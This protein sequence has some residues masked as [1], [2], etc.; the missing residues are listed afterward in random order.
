[1]LHV[2]LANYG[3][4]ALC[5]AIALTQ[6]F[7][8]KNNG[9]EI[10][11][12]ANSGQQARILFDMIKNF[13]ESLDPD[14]LIL[15]RYRDTIKMPI[16]KSSVLVLNSDAM[17]QDGGGYSLFIEDEFAAAKNWDIWNVLVSGQG[18]QEQPL[19][20]AI[21]SANFLLD[22]FPAF[23]WRKTCMEILRGEKKDDSTF[24]ALY[25]L[26]SEDD[27]EHDESCWIKANPSLGTTVSYDFV[28]NQVTDAK[29]QTALEFSVKTKTFNIFC[30][31]SDTWIPASYVRSCMQEVDIKD[32]I[33]Q[34]CYVGV[35]LSSVS[36]LTCWSI[37]FPPDE[38]REKWPDK[39]VFKTFIYVPESTYYESINKQLYKQWVNKGVVILTEG[40]V[41]SYDK[42]L[43]DQVDLTDYVPYATVAY[44]SWNATQWAINAT[45]AGLPLEPYAQN[46]GNFNKPTKFLEMLIRSGRCII[47]DNI[48]VMWM[49]NNV[50]LKIDLNE[51]CKCDKAT[52]EAKIDAC[53]SM[54]MAL[55]GYLLQG[56][57]DVEIL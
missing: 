7:L 5:A 37:C 26:D 18:F 15:Q 11:C 41:V 17:T 47:D 3:K 13:G 45:Q 12:V 1:M 8:D 55:G 19:G 44:D 31:S 34:Y 33:N 16:T 43:K 52:P 39:Y 54:C 27:W 48:S 38:T 24:A 51:N 40:N 29:N 21:S 20:I 56:G 25:E 9:Q 42:I 35:D 36:D 22:G 6:L 23:D 10:A 57:T 30:Q 49:F 4:T 50:K 32:F 28:R 46:L 53:I 14:G 2:K